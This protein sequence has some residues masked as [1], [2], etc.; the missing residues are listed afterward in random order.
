[1]LL[2]I[3]WGEQLPAAGL[4]MQPEQKPVAAMKEQQCRGGTGGSAGGITSNWGVPGVRWLL[5][6]WRLPTLGAAAG[7][8][9]HERLVFRHGLQLPWQWPEWWYWF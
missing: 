9:V 3:W 2:T 1:M 5:A 7:L 6:L 8:A 4:Y